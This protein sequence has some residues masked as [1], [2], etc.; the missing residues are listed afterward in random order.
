MHRIARQKSLKVTATGT[1]RKFGYGFLF[2]FRSEI[3]VANRDFFHISFAFDDPI[4]VKGKGVS[5]GILPS[6]WVRKN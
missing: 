3:L 4:S 6:R 5:N 1:I 2:A